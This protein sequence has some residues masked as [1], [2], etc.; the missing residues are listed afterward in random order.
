MGLS[1]NTNSG[2]DKNNTSTFWIIWKAKFKSAKSS[3]PLVVSVSG[4]TD[5][6]LIEIVSL[7]ILAIFVSQI[8]LTTMILIV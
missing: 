2:K 3:K 5:S 4:L 7:N 8:R 6:G 1:K